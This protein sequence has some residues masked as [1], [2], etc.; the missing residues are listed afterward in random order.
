[1]I[2]AKC[3]PALVQR[4]NRLETTVLRYR[5]IGTHICARQ[6]KYVVNEAPQKFRVG[7]SRP[8]IGEKLRLQI[9]GPYG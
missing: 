2:E 7:M 6:T 8:S 5:M 9:C 3:H 1:M 4:N